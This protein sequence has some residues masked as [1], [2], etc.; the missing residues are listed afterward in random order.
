MSIKFSDIIEKYNGKSDFSDWIDRLEM[1]ADLQDVKDL[2]KF[3]PLFLIDGALAVYKGFD[4]EVRKDY[5]KVKLLM[6]DAFCKDKFTV[7]ESLLNRKLKHN[8][9]VDVYVADL[10]RMLLL[11]DRN[12]SEEFIKT[13][14]VHGLP[15]NVKMQLKAACSLTKMTLDEIVQRSRALINSH[16]DSLETCC[17]GKSERQQNTQYFNKERQV[18][19]YGC[20]KEG[21]TR[22]R[23]PNVTSKNRKCF[24]CGEVGHFIASC[25]SKQT[26]I[27]KNE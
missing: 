12:C 15:D 9:S 8:E 1:I 23:C 20:G 4:P 19:C 27:T 18:V 3:M 17:V 7:Y 10:K 21:H 13:S 11:I 24:R 14:F 2:A 26:S 5:A 16:F 6:I 22:N 25:P